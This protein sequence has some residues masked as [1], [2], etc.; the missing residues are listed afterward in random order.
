MDQGNYSISSRDLYER[1]VSGGAPSLSMLGATRTSSARI[2]RA[3]ISVLS[4]AACSRGRLD[5]RRIFPM[6]TR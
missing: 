5:G 3:T 4:V 2:V 1:L 6:T